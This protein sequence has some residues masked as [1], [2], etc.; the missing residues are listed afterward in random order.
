MSSDRNFVTYYFINKIVQLFF[1]NILKT[2][3]RKLSLKCFHFFQFVIVLKQPLITFKPE[4]A[5]TPKNHF[6]FFFIVVLSA[7]FIENFKLYFNCV[8]IGSITH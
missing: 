4:A 7:D 3:R 2:L 6:F 8:I 1:E 5:S